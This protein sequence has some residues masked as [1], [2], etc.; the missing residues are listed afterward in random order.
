MLENLYL[1]LNGPLFMMGFMAT[2]FYGVYFL[3]IAPVS[4]ETPASKF[5]YLMLAML[6][7][8]W[9]MFGVSV[10]TLDLYKTQTLPPPAK[11]TMFMFMACVFVPIIRERIMQI[12]KLGKYAPKD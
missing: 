12:R 8:S 1:A 10:A 4:K 6:G 2:T 11:I 9:V 3:I 7:T 5:A